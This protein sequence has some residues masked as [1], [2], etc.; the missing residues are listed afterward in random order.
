MKLKNVTFLNNDMK[1]ETRDFS[2]KNNTISFDLDDGDKEILMDCKD[3]LVLPGLFNAHFHSY[4]PL[5][6]GLMQEMA[7]QDWCNDSEQGKIQ[8]ILFDYLENEISERDFGYIAQKSYID[9]VKNGVTF[10]SDSDPQSPQKLSDVMNEIGIRG[11]VDTY[12]EIGSY[13]NK[14]EGNILFGTHL[15]EEEDM[16]NDELLNLKKVKDKYNAI[17]MTHCL[18]N[19]WRLNIVKSKF[20]KSSIELYNE[21]DLLDDKTVLFHGVYMSEEDIELVA[22][23]KSSVV[24]CPLSNLDT[25]AGV[26]DVNAMLEKGVNVCLG[27]DYAHTNVWELMRLTYYLLKI[28]N[29]V[30]KYSAEEIFRM[31]T[32]NGARAYKLQDEIGQIKD[33]YKADLIFIKKDDSDLE[34]LLNKEKFSTYLYN[35]L[36]YSKADSVQ[37]VMIDGK[38]IMKDR[39]LETVDEEKVVSRY[40]QIADG[41]LHYL[42]E[43]AY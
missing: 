6:K 20:G 11:M 9:M 30:N 29:P 5:T 16:T 39:K 24:H 31:A 42:K 14:T 25:G 33:G 1:F 2:I 28:N 4:S 43:R 36:F 41:F 40:N 32:V 17:M 34:P 38:W 23:H 22:K 18:E 27:T 7:L 21:M 8:Q 19:E 3:Y 10:V 37:H 26:A 12:E 15:L 13:N 35:L